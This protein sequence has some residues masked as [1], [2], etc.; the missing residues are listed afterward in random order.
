MSGKLWDS[1]LRTFL[2]EA[3]SSAPTPGGGSVAAVVAA[4]GGAMTQMVAN[5]SQGER[6][7]EVR[8]HMQ[9][10]VQRMN[11]CIDRC[12]QLLQDDIVAFERYMEALRL[13][14]GSPEEK[15]LRRKALE[16]AAV[17]AI[18][19]P[20][21]LMALCR[22]SARCAS[23]IAATSNKNVASDLGIGVILFAAASRS[24]ALTVEINLAQL[25]ADDRKRSIV[26]RMTSLSEEI[27]TLQQQVLATVR[28]RIAD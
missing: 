2:Q 1:T 19:V 11:E 15:G 4:L 21:R 23:D 22:D 24:A 18:E 12:E 16:T 25:A 7:T 26:E 20:L 3:G 17:Q 28:E 10:A 14:K 6:F 9:D 5:L 8:P 27:E 13:P